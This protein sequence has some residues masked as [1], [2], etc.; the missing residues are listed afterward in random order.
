LWSFSL[1]GRKA[2]P[3][4]VP[5][6][7]ATLSKATFSPDGRWVAY[8][9]GESGTSAIYVQPFPASGAK[10]LIATPGRSPLWS[11]QGNE[12][13]YISGRELF[14]VSLSTQTTFAFSNP[15]RVPIGP[16]QIGEASFDPRPFDI[17]LDGTIF[18]LVSAAPRE[19]TTAVPQIEVDLNWLEDLKRLVPTN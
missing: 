6:E 1:T 8:T 4:G 9:S 15:V 2:E 3:F 7:T 17:S 10:Y 19:G 18:G 14:V 16:I 11:R 5:D 13:F 12:L